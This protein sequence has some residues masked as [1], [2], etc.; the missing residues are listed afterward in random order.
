MGLEDVR[1]YIPKIS[2]YNDPSVMK[3]KTNDDLL[4]SQASLYRT[5]SE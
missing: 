4:Y 1:I 2:R 3:I 5:D